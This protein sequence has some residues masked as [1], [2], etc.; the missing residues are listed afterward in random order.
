M[1]GWKKA[2]VIF[3]KIDG[4]RAIFSADE[5]QPVS[6]ELLLEKAHPMDRKVSL[7]DAAAAASGSDQ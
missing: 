3:C 6:R 2:L 7:A 5:G 4:K 1:P